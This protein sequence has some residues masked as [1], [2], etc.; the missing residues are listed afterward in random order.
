MGLSGQDFPGRGLGMNNDPAVFPANKDETFREEQV[1]S[2][3][4]CTG[5]VGRNFREMRQ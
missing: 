4:V 1:S 2:C 3:D 5:A